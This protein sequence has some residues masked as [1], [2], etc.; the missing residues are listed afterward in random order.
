MDYNNDISD[1]S[2]KNKNNQ[3]SLKVTTRSRANSKK[4]KK[5]LIHVY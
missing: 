4:Q 3:S 2:E 1:T 5:I